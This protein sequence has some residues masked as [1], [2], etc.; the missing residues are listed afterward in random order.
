MTTKSKTIKR[1]AKPKTAAPAAKKLTDESGPLLGIAARIM[2][3]SADAEPNESWR[4]KAKR[5]WAGVED[6]SVGILRAGQI[7]RDA[8]IDVDFAL[9]SICMG[10]EG[11]AA[12]REKTDAGLARISRAIDA[13]NKTHGLKEGEYWPR[14]EAPDDVEELNV[15]FERR[16]REIEAAVLREYGENEMADAL[17]ADEDAFNAKYRE[18]GRLAHFGPLPEW[19]AEKL[20][21][22]RVK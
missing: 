16:V 22:R 12:D 3:L 21:G 4:V 17:L 13:A 5:S 19:A 15:A 6:T 2:R 14:G 11:I 8:D 1:T 20:R 18:P 7:M 9:F 10:A